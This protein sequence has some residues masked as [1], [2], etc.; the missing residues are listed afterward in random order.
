MRRGRGSHPLTPCV[1]GVRPPHP[2]HLPSPPPP[3]RYLEARSMKQAVALTPGSHSL[4]SI[5]TQLEFTFEHVLRAASPGSE[6]AQSGEAAGDAPGGKGATPSVA[7]RN[8][9]R[10]VRIPYSP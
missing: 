1:E 5:S 9:P 3:Y 4:E 2:S 10:T 8:G 6:T 7:K